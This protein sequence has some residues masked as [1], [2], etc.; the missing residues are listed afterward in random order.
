MTKKATLL[1]L[2]TAIILTAGCVNNG[3]ENGRI[4]PQPIETNSTEL[5]TPLSTFGTN[6]DVEVIAHTSYYFANETGNQIYFAIEYKNSGDCPLIVNNVSVKFRVN[7]AEYSKD[8]EPVSYNYYVVFPNES[9][10]IAIWTDDLYSNGAENVNIEI[11]DVS[12]DA[13]PKIPERNLVEVKNVKIVQNFADFATV[14]GDIELGS[15]DFTACT[16]FCAFY[17]EANAL[18]GVWYFSI[19]DDTESFT[20]QLISLPIPE[21][22][23]KTK[24]I[25]AIGFGI[26]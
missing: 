1:I 21:L 13:L 23:Q 5:A 6:I 25:K 17:D 19:F 9:G 3:S 15:T 7:D 16:V 18:L 24:S 20:T 14:T 22:A 26:D 2:A 4:T 12:L 8:F 11:I 10:Y